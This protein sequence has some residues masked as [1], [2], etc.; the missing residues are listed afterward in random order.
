MS[1]GKLQKVE[2]GMFEK[3]YS[4]VVLSKASM[5]AFHLMERGVRFVLQNKMVRFLHLTMDDTK[6]NEPNKYG[7]DIPRYKSE[8]TVSVLYQNEKVIEV[9][10][11]IGLMKC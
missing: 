5:F 11:E 6:W 3:K 1:L 4:P 7:S 10:A 8:I 2:V 9:E